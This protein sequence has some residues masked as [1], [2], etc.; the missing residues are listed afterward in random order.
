M[1]LVH[2]N[3]EV[4]AKTSNSAIQ[5]SKAAASLVGKKLILLFH[6]FGFVKKK[7]EQITKI[8]QYNPDAV[9]WIQIQ[10]GK[11]YPQKKKK[12]HKFLQLPALRFYSA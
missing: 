11:N 5:S 3:A 1:A 9:L 4:Y 12:V 8:R 10:E 2:R 6:K 7:K